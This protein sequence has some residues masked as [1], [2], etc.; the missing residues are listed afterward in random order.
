[1]NAEEAHGECAATSSEE[2]VR[3]RPS[4]PSLRERYNRDGVVSLNEQALSRAL[5]R[6]RK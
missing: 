1:M 3:L 5:E 2:A 6:A 4:A